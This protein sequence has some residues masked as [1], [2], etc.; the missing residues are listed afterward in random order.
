MLD[1]LNK[2]EANLIPAVVT[3]AA[4]AGIDLVSNLFVLGKATKFAP[5]SLGRDLLRGRIKQF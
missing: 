3:G 1:I 5:K 4:N 2:G